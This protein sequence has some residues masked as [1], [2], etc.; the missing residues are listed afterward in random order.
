MWWSGKSAQNVIFNIRNH[1]E[2]KNKLLLPEKVFDNNVQIF[3]AS[4]FIITKF[5]KT[6]RVEIQHIDY[7]GFY[8]VGHYY[9]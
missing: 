5:V 3:D 2:R 4:P 1:N 6:H 7:D 8:F 9:G